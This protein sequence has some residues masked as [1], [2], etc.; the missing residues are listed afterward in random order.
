MFYAHMLLSGVCINICYASASVYQARDLRFLGLVCQAFAGL[1]ADAMA[2]YG[3]K[4]WMFSTLDSTVC[5][6]ISE[7]QIQD[8]ITMSTFLTAVGRD[9]HSVTETVNLIFDA[10]LSL[11]EFA[12]NQIGDCVKEKA[13]EKLPDCIKPPGPLPTGCRLGVIANNKQDGTVDVLKILHFEN[14]I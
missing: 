10:H 8:P 9:L 12:L 2:R 4:V 6:S 14:R 11:P 1:L 5:A 3:G 7:D 13:P